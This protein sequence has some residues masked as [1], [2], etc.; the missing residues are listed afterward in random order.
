MKPKKQELTLCD[1]FFRLRPEEML[2]HRH[3]LY[4][5]AERLIGR[6]GKS[7]FAGCILRKADQAYPSG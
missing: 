5:L 2:N 6:Q 7:G 1:D 4:W 3:E